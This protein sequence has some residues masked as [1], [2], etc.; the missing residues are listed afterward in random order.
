MENFNYILDQL[1]EILDT[2]KMDS[3]VFTFSKES[4][5]TEATNLINKRLWGNGAEKIDCYERGAVSKDET[6][7]FI[8]I[9]G[10]E[11]EFIFKTK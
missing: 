8:N 2:P 9:D 5:F 10:I 7:Y 11:I 6:H 3:I 4:D 1:H